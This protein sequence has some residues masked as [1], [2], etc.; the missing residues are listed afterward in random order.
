MTL[1]IYVLL[2]S[3]ALLV[4]ALPQAPSHFVDETNLDAKAT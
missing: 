1:V 2:N 3:R 4:D